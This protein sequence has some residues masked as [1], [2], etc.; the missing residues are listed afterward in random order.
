MHK[1][2]ALFI[3]L[4]LAVAANA[5]TNNSPD[6]QEIKLTFE[7]PSKKLGDRLFENWRLDFR[8]TSLV[9]LKPNQRWAFDRYDLQ[10]Q[11][12]SDRF[13]YRP[14]IALGI[15]DGL[16]G[17][18]VIHGSSWAGR[19]QPRYISFNLFGIIPLG[20]MRVNGDRGW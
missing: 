12:S 17:A 10:S 6:L 7:Q 14:D 1:L 5:Q 18:T 15:G 4:A 9:W 13:R 19:T 8:G 16:F 20:R 11:L 2:L 3:A